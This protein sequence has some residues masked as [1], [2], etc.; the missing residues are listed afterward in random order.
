[1]CF[2]SITLNPKQKKNSMPD[3][4]QDK[5][6][7]NGDGSGLVAYNKYGNQSIFMRSLKIGRRIIE[8]A[9]T[10]PLSIV[11][12]RSATTG[13]VTKENVH[14]WKKRG[15]VFAHNGTLTGL[16]TK[17][18]S[19]SHIFFEML[20]DQKILQAKDIDIIAV[21]ALAKQFHLWGRFTLVNEATKTMYLF[22]S[23]DVIHYDDVCYITS[24]NIKLITPTYLHGIRF[25]QDASGMLEAKLDGVYKMDMKTLELECLKTSFN[26]YSYTPT[27]ISQATSNAIGFKTPQP[28]LAQAGWGFGDDIDDD[29]YYDNDIGDWIPINQ[30]KYAKRYNT[31]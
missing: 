17:E 16:G 4:I 19:D 11:H 25:I 28:H 6:T 15:W 27:P 7:Y 12:L 23:W 9:S 2:I 13:D 20:L 24:A 5:L 30:R 18:F 1:M 21:E 8:Q 26:T 22:G 14:M 29:L 3:I 10:N 31:R